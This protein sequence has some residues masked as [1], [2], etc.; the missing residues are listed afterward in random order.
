MKYPCLI[1][2]SVCKTD[3]HIELSQE[4]VDKYGEPL[5]AIIIDNVKCNYQDTA[6]TVFTLEKKEVKLTGCIYIPG[7]IA[8]TLPTLSGGT[9]TIFEVKRRIYQ[10]TK[11]R[12]P[13]G[14]VN[15]TMLEVE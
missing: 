6:K 7:D 15:Y 9:A 2:K 1:P 13:D 12:N 3:V 11:A 8:P 5:A 10:G 14:T 4:G